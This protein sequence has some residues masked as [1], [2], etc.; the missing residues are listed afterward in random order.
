MHGE[1]VK[2]Q[3]NNILLKVIAELLSLAIHFF[4]SYDR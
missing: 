4:F 3:M 1:T 2:I